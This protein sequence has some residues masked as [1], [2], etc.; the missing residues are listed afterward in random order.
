MLGISPLEPYSKV[1][2]KEKVEER[3]RQKEMKEQMRK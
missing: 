3:K 2:V 1:I